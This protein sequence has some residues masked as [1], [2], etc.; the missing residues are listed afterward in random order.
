MLGVIRK[1]NPSCSDLY[2]SEKWFFFFLL[3]LFSYLCGVQQDK[4]QGGENRLPLDC[5]FE[6]SV[7]YRHLYMQGNQSN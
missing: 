1:F 5:Y 2:F 7:R 3:F 4:H 6:D